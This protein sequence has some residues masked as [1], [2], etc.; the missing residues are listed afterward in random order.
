MTDNVLLFRV[1]IGFRVDGKHCRL[2]VDLM[3]DSKQKFRV[4][5][6]WYPAMLIQY[7][8]KNMIFCGTDLKIIVFVMKQLMSTIYK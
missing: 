6:G 5:F 3:L 4:R 8:M 1:L 2:W 7:D